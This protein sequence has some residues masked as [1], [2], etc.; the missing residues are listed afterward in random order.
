MYCTPWA[1]LMKSITPNTSVSPAATRNSRMPSCSP[2]NSW[3]RKR[4]A[5]M[6]CRQG[7][8]GSDPSR[9]RSRQERQRRCEGSDP[10]C[11]LQRALAGVAVGGV[12]EH[13]LHD[14][15]LELAVGALG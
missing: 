2:L 11:L 15:R 6:G 5:D 12:R 9:I 3:T 4:A 7:S 14:L 1:R 8:L 10:V 13:L